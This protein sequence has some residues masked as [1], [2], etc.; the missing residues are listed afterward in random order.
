MWFQ[1]FFR[2][3][4]KPHTP[5]SARWISCPLNAQYLRGSRR[6]VKLKW[7]KREQCAC[8]CH[9]VV[10]LSLWQ[11]FDSPNEI[12]C[13]VSLISLLSCKYHATTVW[14]CAVLFVYSIPYLVCGSSTRSASLLIIRRFFFSPSLKQYAHFELFV[15]A[16]RWSHRSSNPHPKTNHIESTSIHSQMLFLLLFS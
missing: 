16:I 13:P 7:M 2:C 12:R 5:T 10:I 4:H 8:F 3:S 6:K 15:F 11:L 14:F 9:W 1:L